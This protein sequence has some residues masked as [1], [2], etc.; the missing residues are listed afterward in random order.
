MVILLDK[1]AAAPFAAK[2]IIPE[3]MVV[4]ILFKFRDESGFTRG[5]NTVPVPIFVYKGEVLV[6][7]IQSCGG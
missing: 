1:I 2:I 7:I 4:P 6:V 3:E 5:E